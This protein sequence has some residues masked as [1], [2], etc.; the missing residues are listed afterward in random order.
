MQ[1]FELGHRTDK[2]TDSQTEDHSNCL[3]VGT[4]EAQ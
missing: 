3:M 2:N 1:V 4:R